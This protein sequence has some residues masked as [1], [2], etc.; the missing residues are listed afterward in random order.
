MLG[1]E[2]VSPKDIDICG[3]DAVLKRN[4]EV[5]AEGEATRCWAIR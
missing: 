4:G 3:I 1:R 5:V 2:R